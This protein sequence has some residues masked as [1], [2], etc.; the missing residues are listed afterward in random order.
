MKQIE[1]KLPKEEGE[2]IYEYLA[3]Y[4]SSAVQDFENFPRTEVD[5]VEDDVRLILDE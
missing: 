2:W 3:G 5:L 4:T 1:K